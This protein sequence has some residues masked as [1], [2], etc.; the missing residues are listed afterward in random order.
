ML[1]IVKYVCSDTR[2]PKITSFRSE[3][4]VVAEELSKLHRHVGQLLPLLLP[5]IL[6]ILV[7][8]VTLI[9]ALVHFV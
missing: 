1:R 5:R 7:T 6:Q 9:A 2:M 8:L 4:D 3:C